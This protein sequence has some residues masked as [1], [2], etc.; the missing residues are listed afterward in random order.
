MGIE[1]ASNRLAVINQR[2]T[3]ARYVDLLLYDTTHL[4]SPK[5]IENASIAGNYVSA[6]LTG[7]NL[8]AIIQQPSFRYRSLRQL[9]G[10]NARGDGK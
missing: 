3:N 5:L 9:D 2:N 10:S 7:G 4:S 6:R 8:Y 1:I